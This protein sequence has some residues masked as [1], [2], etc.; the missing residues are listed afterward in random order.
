M[1][2][3]D[4][5]EV[6]PEAV[7]PPALPTAALQCDPELL[8]GAG[9]VARDAPCRECGYNLRGLHP[10]DRCPECAAPVLT[11]IRGNFLH[12]SNLHWRARV[13][14]GVDWMLWAGAGV[15]LAMV[16]PF[17]QVYIPAVRIPTAPLTF[18]MQLAGYYGVWLCTTPEPGCFEKRTSVRACAR[19]AVVAWLGLRV[20]G[21]LAA[22]SPFGAFVGNFFR[23]CAG[24]AADVAVFVPLARLAAR[25]PN[26]P[27]AR[28][29]VKLTWVYAVGIAIVLA[30]GLTAWLCSLLGARSPGAREFMH[31][32]PVYIVVLMLILMSARL[33][34]L[35]IASRALGPA[36]E[37]S[38]VPGRASDRHHP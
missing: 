4:D 1:A 15:L 18:I 9:A 28:R 5:S 20:L 19:V 7:G 23:A 37:E 21:W 25:I 17:V 26:A 31:I 36:T 24:S 10:E 34:V 38:G 27:L 33:V 32:L 30:M 22:A 13:V 6:Y 12:F 3:A 11:T 8:D 29:I 14:T 2:N 16:L 35:F